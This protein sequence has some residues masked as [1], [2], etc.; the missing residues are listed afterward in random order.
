MARKSKLPIVGAEFGGGYFVDTLMVKGK[1]HLLIVAPK[2]DGEHEPIEY[3]CYGTL[4]RGA[5]SFNDGIAN[6]RALA[7]AGSDMAK[8]AVAL[9][10]G[11]VK[12]WAVPAR[13]QLERL[14]RALKPT[15]AE[16][17]KRCGDNPSAIPPAYPYEDKFPKQTAL[18][19]FKA[20]AAEALSDSW[21]WSSTQ[22]S[23]N[24]AW[25][26][27]FNN[28]TQDWINKNDDSRVRAVRVIP[29]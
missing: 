27:N 3:G 12:D 6:T 25:Y 21:Y 15:K 19:L 24:Y 2:A 23:A 17:Y 20:G 7:R 8:W 29:I 4:V 28:G 9:R 1:P 18:K 22:Y 13:D 10:I 26:Q 11:G 14:Y 5:G 16:N